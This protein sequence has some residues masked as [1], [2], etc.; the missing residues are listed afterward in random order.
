MDAQVALGHLLG[1]SH[2]VK[3]EATV[4]TLTVVPQG[5][6]SKSGATV[7]TDTQ[8][9]NEV[10]LTS[11]LADSLPCPAM[12]G[13]YPV[14]GGTQASLEMEEGGGEH[15]GQLLGLDV[16]K[17]REGNQLQRGRIA[18]AAGVSRSCTHV[19]RTPRWSAITLWL[20]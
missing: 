13:G 20:R 17:F 11:M 18:T 10:M 19:T 5:W 2:L 3:G 16:G 4:F 6:G 15:S 12:H 14:A 9:L 7:W 1:A 8:K